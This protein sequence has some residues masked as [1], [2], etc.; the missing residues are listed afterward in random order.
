MGAERN[1]AWRCIEHRHRPLR[2]IESRAVST[3]APM[4]DLN[5]QQHAAMTYIDG[6]VLV[7]AGAG[8]GKTRVVTRRIARL[9]R[10]G[11][12]SREILALTFTNKAAGEMQKRVQE[13]GGEFVRVATFHSASA[14]FLRSEGHLLGFRPDYTIYDT[15]DRDTL[16][17]ELMGDLHV[18]TTQA[19]PSMVGQWISRLK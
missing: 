11:V 18:S 17:K 7:L 10:D 13:L 1:H 3:R 12:R 4:P 14:R 6:P 19:K 15:H 8:S 2:G 5:P 9:L 16:L